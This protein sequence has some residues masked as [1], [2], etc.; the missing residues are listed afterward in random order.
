MIK[1]NYLEQKQVPKSKNV[2]WIWTNQTNKIIAV[3]R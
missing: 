2:L 3:T 1:E